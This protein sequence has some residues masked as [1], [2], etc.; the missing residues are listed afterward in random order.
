MGKTKTKKPATKVVAATANAP[1][2][3]RPRRLKAVSY[4]SFRLQRKIAQVE[5]VT[6]SFKVTKKA[7]VLLWQNKL[8]FA[9]I[10]L[11]YGV[12]NIILVRGLAGSVDVASLKDQIDQAFNGQLGPFASSLTVFAVLV[13]SSGSG[14]SSAASVYQLFLVLIVSLAVI[15]TLRQRLAGTSVRIRDGFYQG[16]HPLIPFILVLLVVGLQLLPL[17][18][19]VSL[20]S[21]VVSNGIAVYAIEEIFWVVLLILLVL[22]SLYMICSSVFALYIVTLPDMT[23]MKALRSARELVRH[24][25][26]QILRKI[27]FLPVIM[28][29]IA[30]LIVVPVIIVA[31]PAAQWVVFVLSMIAIVVVHAYMYV[32]YRELL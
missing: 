7:A 14:T 6:S 27:L 1:A 15:W 8:L 5:T 4:K 30:A 13:G 11:I 17:V 21:L 24:R 28:L 22:L 2:V 23:P 20:Y 18:I 10:A 16:M 12:L 25:R 3:K 26:W 29:I 19:G 32:L 9:G 31:A